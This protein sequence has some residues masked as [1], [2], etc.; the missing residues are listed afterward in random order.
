[1][2]ARSRGPYYH[3]SDI[4]KSCSVPGMV[5]VRKKATDDAQNFGFETATRI[6][7]FISIGVFEDI[8]LDNSDVLDHEPD[9]GTPF[10]AY[11]FRIGPKHV[12]FAFY[13][14]PNGT[15]IIKSFH[16]P[17]IGEKAPQLSHSPFNLL[18]GLKK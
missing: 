7:E 13:K 14:R 1:M 4:V 18:E 8:E 10:D 15:W 3:L 17:N 5:H 9:K 11:I 6:I 16:T 2:V 12:Y